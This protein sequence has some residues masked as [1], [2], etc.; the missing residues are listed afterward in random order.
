MVSV[1]KGVVENEAVV[2]GFDFVEVVEVELAHE[3]RELL[4]T[5][6]L[7]YYLGLK[8]LLIFDEYILALAVPAYRIRILVI[9]HP[10]NL[11]SS[12]EYS[13]LRNLLMFLLLAIN[14]IF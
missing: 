11:T 4:E 9:L 5:K 1:V 10:L 7:G 13:F 12:S 6:I 14:G 3:A 2:F 8:F